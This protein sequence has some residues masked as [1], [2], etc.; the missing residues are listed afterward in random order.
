MIVSVDIGGTFTDYIMYHHGKIKTYKK[1]TTRNPEDGIRRE[2]KN[3]KIEE[4]YHGSTIAV[5]AILERRGEKVILV[6]T[7][8]FGTLYKIGRQN[9]R[10]IYSF[11][12]QREKIPVYDFIEVDERVLSNGKIER[13]LDEKELE[14]KIKRK[15]GSSCAILF[16]NSYANPENEIKAKKILKKYCNYVVA[17]YEVRREIREYER[18]S[19][20]VIESYIYPLL[21]SYF[22]RIKE[23]GRKIYVM[24][25]NGGKIEERYVKGINTIMSGPAGGVAAGEFLSRIF[26]EGN[27]LTYDM[28][29]TSADIGM[30]VDGN[31]LYTSTI[32]VDGI[33]IKATSMDIISIGSGG[34]SIAWID[35]GFSLRVG[36][37]SAGSKPGPACYSLGGKEFTV[38]DADLLLGILG[39]EISGIKLD[40]KMAVRAAGKFLDK[41]NLDIEEFTR[42]VIKIVNNNMA[43][44]LKKI[45]IEK[46]YDPRNFTLL[47]FGGAGPMHA[48]SLAEEV[49]IK[50]II[51]PPMAGTF[52]SL[53]ILLSPLRYDYTKTILKNIEDSAEYINEAIEEFEKDVKKKLRNYRIHV[54]L[55]MRY[56]GQGHELNVPLSEYIKEDFR[57][58]HE[59]IFGFSMDEMIEVVNINLVATSIERDIK[60]PKVEMGENRIKG[61]RTYNFERKIPVYS[62]SN[63]RECSNC[64]IEADTH[65]VFVK[66]GW[67]ARINE[68]GAIIMERET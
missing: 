23:V 60:L 30:I 34:G 55:D 7:K 37:R 5:N 11:T 24:Q 10:E 14:E 64:I 22:G 50:K 15:K 40:K 61:R 67:N 27:M 52:S 44:A 68:F 46:G 35:D 28:G 18:L 36:P 21:K 1:L 45:S 47:A 29:G 49:G 12:P 20:T 63:F 3:K 57:K 38:T 62:I 17:S 4:F 51:I 13:E 54:S 58:I 56:R 2:L 65:T 16:I 59:K 6:T 33:P 9:R 39:E 19:T 66:E 25:S 32:Y 8:G 53:G 48:C 26:N 43:M 31:P 41:L 42:G